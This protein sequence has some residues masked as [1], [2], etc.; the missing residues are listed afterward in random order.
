M[1]VF[2]SVQDEFEAIAGIVAEADT[3]EEI[4]EQNASE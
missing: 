2:Q 4:G 1:N 3:W